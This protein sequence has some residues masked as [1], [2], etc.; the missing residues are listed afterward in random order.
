MWE[1]DYKQSR[2]LKNW[3]FWNVVLQMVL[4]SP[5]DCKEIQPVHPKRDQSLV[6]IGRTD[7]EAETS[8]FWPPDKNSWLIWKDPV[9]RKNWGQDKKGT[10]RGW[11][12]WM[13]SPTQITWVWVDSGS[14]W[15]QEGL[16]CCFSWG[17]KELDPTEW[18][19]WT[20]LNWRH[21]YVIL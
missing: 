16:V 12:G 2:A 1:L 15:G 17:F 14:L 13:A 19:K 18:L 20:E 3:C 9:A 21:N 7:V 11:D 10:T 5:L 4:E 6:F 8:I